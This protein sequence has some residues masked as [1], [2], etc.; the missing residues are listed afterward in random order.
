MNPLVGRPGGRGGPDHGRAEVEGEGELPVIVG[1][2][3]QQPVGGEFLQQ[4]LPAARGIHQCRGLEPEADGEIGGDIQRVRIRHGDVLA[5]AIEVERAV[6]HATGAAR[7][8]DERAVIVAGRIKRGGTT[9]LVELPMR[10]QRYGRHDD[11]GHGQGEA[12]AR[13]QRVIR[14]RERDG[15][16]AGLAGGGRDGERAID[17]A[18]TENKTGIRNERLIGGNRRHSKAAGRGFVVAHGEGNRRQRLA[19]PH[20]TIRKTGDSGSSVARRHGKGEGTRC[21]EGAVADAD[22]DGR[23][24]GLPGG[25]SDGHG[26]IGSGAG[27]KDGGIGHQTLIG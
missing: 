1:I 23:R 19:F 15:D 7:R 5:G 8:I 21:R 24:T 17:A 27:E 26:A 22:G 11:V 16:T 6:A 3:H 13:R 10:H 12:V 20:R 4:I 14:D 2:V 18:A 25:R 9:A